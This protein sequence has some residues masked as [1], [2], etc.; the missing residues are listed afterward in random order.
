MRGKL[1]D[2][3]DVKRE[4]MKRELM[5]R[6]SSKKDNRNLQL[7]QTQDEDDEL[8]DEDDELTAEEEQKN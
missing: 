1:R 8:L 4:H 7:L 3:R 6:R 5:G 2:K